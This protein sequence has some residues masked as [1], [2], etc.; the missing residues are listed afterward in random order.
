MVLK[1]V[2]YHP[3]IAANL[4]SVPAITKGGNCVLFTPTQAIMFSGDAVPPPNAIK[5]GERRN[6]AYMLDVE[7][8]HALV[9]ENAV[10]DAGEGGTATPAVNQVPS[11][12]ITASRSRC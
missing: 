2:G 4:L 5:I 12:A 10:G 7:Q 8:A 1:D 6:D 9:M 11:D 3:S